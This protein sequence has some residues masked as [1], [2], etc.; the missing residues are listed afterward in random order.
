MTTEKLKWEQID[1]ICLAQRY[2]FSYFVCVCVAKIQF[3]HRWICLTARTGQ[4]PHP[5]PRAKASYLHNWQFSLKQRKENFLSSC[6]QVFLTSNNHIHT[7][8]HLCKHTG[9][10]AGAHQVTLVNNWK[11][12]NKKE[13]KRKSSSLS[14][15]KEEQLLLQIQHTG[16][17]HT[18]HLGNTAG[19]S[20][21]HE[22]LF[23]NKQKKWN[24]NM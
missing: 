5:P 22:S 10:E 7:H 6:C 14:V 8:T 9:P 20:L 2:I 21:C 23:D 11:E 18:Q 17:R 4:W 24:T 19:L 16:S 15:I 3:R 12:K 1:V 13:E